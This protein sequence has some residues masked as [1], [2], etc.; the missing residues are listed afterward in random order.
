MK[1]RTRGR[2]EIVF[3]IQNYIHTF[4]TDLGVIIKSFYQSSFA[5]HDKPK[6]ASNSRSKLIE[7][8]VVLIIFLTKSRLQDGMLRRLVILVTV[9]KSLHCYSSGASNQYKKN[10]AD[11][12]ASFFLYSCRQIHRML[13]NLHSKK[14]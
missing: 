14:L 1:S 12:A 4:V 3:T 9:P 13:L 6:H 7:H 11:I 8:K 2:A 10:V 5:S